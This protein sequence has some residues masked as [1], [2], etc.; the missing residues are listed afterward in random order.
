LDAPEVHKAAAAGDTV[1][2][3]KTKKREWSRVELNGW[4]P[5]HDAARSGH[6]SIVKVFV[7][8]GIDMDA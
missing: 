2:L 4:Q 5:I 7:K 1:K 6:S 3:W 8:S